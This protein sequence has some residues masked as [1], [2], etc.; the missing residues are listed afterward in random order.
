[1]FCTFTETN[2]DNHPDDGEVEHHLEL[3]AP[4]PGLEAGRVDGQGA[5][6]HRGR[7]VVGDGLLEAEVAGRRGVAAVPQLAE[8]GCA[9][10]ALGPRVGVPHGVEAVAEVD[11]HP[12]GDDHAVHAGHALHHQQRHAH[13]LQE[14][15]VEIDR[16]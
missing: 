6:Q 9:P 5:L 4:E 1:M 10:L 12:G 2:E 3:E 8:G 11:E 15:I 7:E 16:S 14:D 13:T